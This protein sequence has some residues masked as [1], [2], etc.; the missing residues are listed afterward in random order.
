MLHLEVSCA[1]RR[2]F[3]SLGFKGL[4]KSRFSIQN[5]IEI[6]SVVS[7]K[8]GI[9]WQKL[10]AHISCQ[11]YAAVYSNRILSLAC[12]SEKI[13]GGGSVLTIPYEGKGRIRSVGN[14]PS[15][16]TRSLDTCL[17]VPWRGNEVNI[18]KDKNQD[19]WEK[20][21]RCTLFFIIYFA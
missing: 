15:D 10:H 1:V 11:G 18:L 13:I 20:P 14:H 8:K 17:V 3:K 4:M 12:V 2:F 19:T 6:R 21:T 5:S 16:A 9:Y 7:E